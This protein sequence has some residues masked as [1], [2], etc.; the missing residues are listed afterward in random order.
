MHGS[1]MVQRGGFC[2]FAG[3]G[4]MV[5]LAGLGAGWMVRGF[6]KTASPRAGRRVTQCSSRS[7]QLSNYWEIEKSKKIN[8]KRKT[9]G[10]MDFIC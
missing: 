7:Q 9:C 10:K 1:W 2:V 4:A 8:E 5:Q 6:E 3:D